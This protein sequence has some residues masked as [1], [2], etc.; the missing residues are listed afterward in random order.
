MPI[1]SLHPSKSILQ[2]SKNGGLTWKLHTPLADTAVFNK[3][4][5]VR[6]PLSK[7]SSCQ[8]SSVACSD[9]TTLSSMEWMQIAFPVGDSIRA[10]IV[11]VQSHQLQEYFKAIYERIIR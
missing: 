6:W 10:R 4:P 2:M 9:S 5:G 8:V 1:T 3:T 7:E 11:S